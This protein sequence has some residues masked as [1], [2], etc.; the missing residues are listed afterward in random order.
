MAPLAW[1]GLALIAGCLSTAVVATAF[2][3]DYGYMADELYFLS[4]ADRLAWGYVDHPP[5]SIA[6]L[7]AYRSVFGESLVA[8]RALAALFAAASVFSVGA[9]ARELGGGRSAQLLAAL[10]WA[11]SPG[12]QGVASYY[13]MNVIEGTLWAAIA[14]G[15]VRVVARGE[16]RVWWM[17]GAL[18]GIAML[19]KLSTSWLVAGLG[20][21]LLLGPA[22][23]QL[24]LR[25][26]WV[27]AA[28]ALCLFSPHLAWQV[29]HDWPFLEFLAGY[30][31]ELTQTGDVLLGPRAVAGAFVVIA[32]PLAL[33]LWLAGV[34]NGLRGAGAPRALVVAWGAILVL[35]ATSGR[36]QPHYLAPLLP[37]VL[38]PAAIAFEDWARAR[39]WLLPAAAAALILSGGIALPV[40]M[41]LLPVGSLGSEAPMH[42]RHRIGWP[43][44]A[45]AVAAAAEALPAA[46]REALTV[47]ATGFPIAGALD[48]LGPSLGLPRPIA[49][50]NSYW[51]WGP[52][53]HDGS[54][55]LVVTEPGH[56]VLEAFAEVSAGRPIE[57]AGCPGGVR[58][59]RIFLARRPHRPLSELW[60]H[61]KDYR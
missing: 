47:L 54:V 30:A 21:G 39:R 50:H 51:D 60:V 28:I 23:R 53:G 31:A 58:P 20:L 17:L 9:L 24:R 38:A 5:L 19:N 33:P 55:S 10:A 61:W 56:V 52:G 27:G 35:L 43:Q 32:G 7:G 14:C 12:A 15:A 34:F 4:C 25:H 3:P 22:R 29:G 8:L 36:A 57:C 41:G 46:E 42:L 37:L 40:V 48:R 13:S 1:P 26:P 45:S 44:V 11:A 16:A 2:V 49:T 59:E 6:V 18:A